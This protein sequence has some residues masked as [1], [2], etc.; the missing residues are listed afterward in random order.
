MVSEE[1]HEIPSRDS[2]PPGR[3]FNHGILAVMQPTD[4]QEERKIVGGWGSEGNACITTGTVVAEL[5]W[6]LFL[7]PVQ[8][9]NSF[10]RESNFVDHNTAVKRLRAWN[11]VKVN[12]H[13]FSSLCHGYERHCA[14]NATNLP[15]VITSE[16]SSSTAHWSQLQN[17]ARATS[18]PVQQ[19]S[20]VVCSVVQFSPLNCF[21]GNL[22][23]V[24]FSLPSAGRTWPNSLIVSHDWKIR[25]KL[26]GIKKIWWFY[27]WI[28]VCTWNF[29]DF[30]RCGMME[31]I[32]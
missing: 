18:R 15:V 5:I 3:D 24:A 10:V 14:G 23:V 4:W 22:P 21:S 26:E 6:S 20:S 2:R 12:W 11:S 27:A 28:K 16:G 13:S 1:N 19:R 31:V 9:T 32:Y 8:A 7:N 25:A 29:G 17:I 30:L